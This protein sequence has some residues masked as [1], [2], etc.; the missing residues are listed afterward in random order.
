MDIHN[1]TSN[2]LEKLSP[3]NPRAGQHNDR[4]L[5]PVEECNCIRGMDR[6]N[7]KAGYGNRI[8]FK[9]RADLSQPLSGGQ[10]EKRNSER[11]K[12]NLACNAQDS[13]FLD[14]PPNENASRFGLLRYKNAPLEAGIQ[15]IANGVAGL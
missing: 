1:R 8:K 3:E 10:F 4:W 5:Q 11:L 2:M 9:F 6:W 12:G 15:I 13:K 7:F 14:S